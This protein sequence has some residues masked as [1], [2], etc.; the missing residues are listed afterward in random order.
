MRVGIVGA[1]I[2]GLTAAYRLAQMG[3]QVAVFEQEDQL[4]GQ[5]R[6]FPVAGEPLEGFYHHIF[7]KD[8]DIIELIQEVGLSS[9]LHWL[10]SRVGFYHGGQIY[11]FVTAGDLLRFSPISLLDRLRL[12]LV[13]LYLR[14]YDNWRALEGIT[15]KDWIVKYAGRRNYEVVWAPLLRGKFGTSHEE[16]GMVWFWGKIHLRFASRGRGSQQEKLGYMDGSFGALIDALALQVK[17]SNGQIL[18]QSRVTRVISQEGKVTGLRVVTNGVEQEHPLDAVVPTVDSGSVAQMA[19]GLPPSYLEKLHRARYQASVCLVLVL[20]HQLTPIYWM[21]I[22]DP[23]MPFVAVIEHTNLVGKDRY[24][25]KT[26]LYLSNYVAQDDP[27]YE[28]DISSLLDLYL[29]GI[30]RLNPAFTLDWIEDARLF[31]DRAGQ[32]IVTTHYSTWIPDH[33]TPIKGFFVA[34]TTQIYPED[35]GINYSVRLGN[36]VSQLVGRMT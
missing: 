17:Q 26:I 9:K 29:P 12:G 35:R 36:R 31:K 22:S 32:P 11:N 5:V 15:A 19:P 30:Q 7:M 18:T 8:A 33:A 2:G 6:T 24:G 1:G 4:G 27:L 21:N 28:K 20:K 3:H 13:A 34:N 14:R 10:D 23:S 16:I 25:G